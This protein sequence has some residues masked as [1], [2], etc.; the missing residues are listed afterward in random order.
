VR[1]ERKLKF[2]P[3]R[4]LLAVSALLCLGLASCHNIHQAHTVTLTWKAP[5]SIPGATIVGY[6]VYRRPSYAGTF[7]KIASGV[8]APPYEDRLILNDRT[9]IYAVSAVDQAGR[10]S[11]LSGEV[12]ATI[13]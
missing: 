1:V 10:E 5:A 8:P 13:P 3:S 6:N 11:R 7:V 9:Y 12:Q 2:D 4:F